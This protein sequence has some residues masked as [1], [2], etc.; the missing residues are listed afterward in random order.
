MTVP[1]NN[2]L[3]SV[4]FAILVSTPALSDTLFFNGDILTMDGPVPVYAEAVVEQDGKIAFVGAK[5]EALAAFPDAA[6]R[7]LGGQTMLPG[8]LDP[9]GHFMFA[10]NMVN[11]VN[12]ANPPVGPTTDIPSTIAALQAFQQE[13]NIQPGE[14]I[15]GWV[16]IKK[17]WPKAAI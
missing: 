17:V 11:Q 5:S 13:R 7:D 6:M 8:F 4:A 3:S 16:M 2:L 14:W 12:V 15:V 1:I 9:H 10:L